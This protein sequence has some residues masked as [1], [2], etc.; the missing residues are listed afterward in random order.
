M[1]GQD[2]EEYREE[3]DV[4][5]AEDLHVAPGIKIRFKESLID[6]FC[7]E[8][9]N[10]RSLYNDA[11]AAYQSSNDQEFLQLLESLQTELRNHLL[12]EALNMYVYLKHLYAKD[13]KKL[14][15]ISRFNRN[16]NKTGMTTF[17]F[18]R[19]FTEDGEAVSHDD[20]FLSQLLNVGNGLEVQLAAEERH[21]F[22]LYKRAE[23]LASA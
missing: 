16:L 11:L 19:R 20:D 12:D 2:T 18:I 22:P 8:H 7:V 17:S 1:L 6:K 4:V 15:L 9:G 13:A 3:S 21:L 14:K 5:G 23:T 10:I